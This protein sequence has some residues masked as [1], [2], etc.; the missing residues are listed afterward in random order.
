ML[1]RQSHTESISRTLKKKELG[2][3]YKLK[4]GYC[5]G[6]TVRLECFKEVIT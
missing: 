1:G 3:F 4:A 2:M 5:D 6:I